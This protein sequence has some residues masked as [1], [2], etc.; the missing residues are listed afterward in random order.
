VYRNV[1]PKVG[2]Q[3]IG[4]LMFIGGTI[5]DEIPEDRTGGDRR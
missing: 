4:I 1:T 3:T 5:E 2:Q